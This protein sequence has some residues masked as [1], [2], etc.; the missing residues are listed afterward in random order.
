MSLKPLLVG[1]VSSYICMHAGSRPGLLGKHDILLLDQVAKCC[2]KALVHVA[3]RPAT[4]TPSTVLFSSTLHGMPCPRSRAQEATLLTSG[5]SSGGMSCSVGADPLASAIFWLISHTSHS[6]SDV[7]RDSP[8]LRS[9][10]QDSCD[11]QSS[12]HAPCDNATQHLPCD[13]GHANEAVGD[14]CPSSVRSWQTSMTV[15]QA[16]CLPEL[17]HTLHNLNCCLRHPIDNHGGHHACA[18]QV[19]HITLLLLGTAAA[20]ATK[21]ALT[22]LEQRKLLKSTQQQ[23]QGSTGLQLDP[24]CSAVEPAAGRVAMFASEDTTDNTLVTETA[25]CTP[26]V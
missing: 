9:T 2:H 6:C 23:Q 22:V 24:Q 7:S 16:D 18:C 10:T 26:A 13:D 12:T 14:A 19:L 20:A 17:A 5:G 15:S 21:G 8:N 11:T 3:G 25:P 4:P 1:S